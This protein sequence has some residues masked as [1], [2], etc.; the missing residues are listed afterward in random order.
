MS[1]I[2]RA[3]ALYLCVA[4]NQSASSAVFDL[5][6]FKQLEKYGVFGTWDD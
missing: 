3:I 6:D 2:L 1:T 5:V 4:F